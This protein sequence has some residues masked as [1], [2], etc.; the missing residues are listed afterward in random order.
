MEKLNACEKELIKSAFRGFASVSESVDRAGNIFLI[1]CGLLAAGMVFH[2]YMIIVSIGWARYNLAFSLLIVAGMLGFLEKFKFFH[3]SVMRRGI[4]EIEACSAKGVEAVDLDK[5]KKEMM[6]NV[7]LLQR[8]LIKRAVKSGKEDP[9]MAM[10]RRAARVFWW[11]TAT[12]ALAFLVLILF[13][14]IA[15]KLI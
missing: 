15:G 9:L 2:R 7:P 12:F 3:V 1:A 10:Y 13:F 8:I 4:V 14:L 6:K 5:L 11:Q